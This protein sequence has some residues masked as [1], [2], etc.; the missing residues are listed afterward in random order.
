MSVKVHEAYSIDSFQDRLLWWDDF[1]G[2]QLKDEWNTLIDGGGAV[3][4]IDAQTGGIVRLTTAATTGLD[5][6][7]NWRT[8]RS[9]LVSK[10]VTMEVR[11]KLVDTLTDR[12]DRISLYFDA[13]NRI[14]FFMGGANWFIYCFD[15]GASTSFDS[16]V[17]P[18]TSY[19]IFRIECHTHG[20]SH[21]HF[22]I[23]GDETDNS[24]ITTNI[25]DDGID[26][27]QPWVQVHTG[28]NVAKSIDIDYVVVRQEI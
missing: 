23:D 12:L 17:G 9:L 1:L 21:V 27:L 14:L 5:V 24:P 13:G 6:T 20:A 8:F 11:L 18:D 7:I 2:D 22:Y 26:Y 10:K 19:H 25:P 15:G 28:E 16:G 4:V 3:D